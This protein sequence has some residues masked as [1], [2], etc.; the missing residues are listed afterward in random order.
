MPLE[1]L[2]PSPQELISHEKRQTNTKIHYL[3]LAFLFT[4]THSQLFIYLNIVK[5]VGLL[6]LIVT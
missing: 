2:M 3:T 4:I 6:L 5:I 1:A